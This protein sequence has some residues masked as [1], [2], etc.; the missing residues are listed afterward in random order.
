MTTDGETVPSAPCGVRSVSYGGGVQ[1]TALLVMAA[2]G[3]INFRSFLFA[4]VGERSEHPDTLGYVRQV[5]MPYAKANGIDLIELR[6]HRRDGSVEDLRD[7]LDIGRMVIPVR[8]SA[9]GPPMSRSCTADFKT[10]VIAKELK[11]RGA[12]IETPATVAL[13]ISL[14][15]VERAKPG[16]DPAEPTQIRTYPL[17]D[18]GI[19]RSTCKSIID[20]AGLPIPK[21]SACFFCPFHDKDAWRTLKRETP[22]LFEQ[23]CKIEA[24]MSA[25]TKD[26]RPVFLTRHG[27]PLTDTLDDQLTLDG[28]DGCD[29]GWCMT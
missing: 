20:A 4:N 24:D 19:T 16:V 28:M 11:R 23:A 10:R 12:T 26:G 15:E 27:I 7:R 1:S 21:K 9:G 18:F 6:R 5:A 2:E 3:V 8:R 29:S 14:D 13:G 17:L 22:D 25:A